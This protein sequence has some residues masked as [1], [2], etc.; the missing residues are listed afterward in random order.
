MRIFVGIEN[1]KGICE[2]NLRSLL[3]QVSC[4]AADFACNT[5]HVCG[6]QTSVLS[7]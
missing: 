6:F 2:E 3:A 1:M 5:V 4:T 7:L